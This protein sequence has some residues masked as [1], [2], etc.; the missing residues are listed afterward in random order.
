MV[1]SCQNFRC[2]AFLVVSE[3]LGGGEYTEMADIPCIAKPSSP[4]RALRPLSVA[5]CGCSRGCR[6]LMVNDGVETELVMCRL[7]LEAASQP[8]PAVESQAR[9]GPSAQL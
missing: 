8:K 1:A 6:I 5:E 9:P 3:T 7:G 4:S 2:D